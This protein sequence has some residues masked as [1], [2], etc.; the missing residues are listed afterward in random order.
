MALI[1]LSKSLVELEGASPVHDG[2]YSPVMQATA[3][4]R[5]KPLSD[6]QA[7]DFRLLIAQH[8]GLSILVPM[9]LDLLEDNPMIQASHYPGDLLCTVAGVMDPFWEANRDLKDRMIDIRYR[10]E[11]LADS[12]R[13]FAL[14]ETRG[15]IWR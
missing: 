1:D 2:A 8:I 5:S 13:D 15:F 11:L 7:E 10:V 12:I 6:L 9:A 4:A 14:P 3:K